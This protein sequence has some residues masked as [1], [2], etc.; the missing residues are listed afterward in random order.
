[1]HQNYLLFVPSLITKSEPIQ[2]SIGADGVSEKEYPQYEG[3]Q[4]NEA[5]TKF[6]I[7]YLSKA[8]ESLDKI[9]MLCTEEVR[10]DIKPQIG[11]RTTLDY[12]I[13]SIT[14]FLQQRNG[15]TEGTKGLFQ[16]I[17][18]VPQNNENE[19]QIIE[20]LTNVIH[21]EEETK[22]KKRIYIDFTGG[23]RSAALTLVFAGRILDKSGVEVAKILYSNLKM[24][25]A[26]LVG[27]IEECTKT[28]QIFSAFEK[29]IKITHNIVDH[30]SSNA[31]MRENNNLIVAYKMSQTHIAEES[32]KKIDS[33]AP[34]Q[35][36]QELSYTEKQNIQAIQRKSRAYQKGTQDPLFAI[37][38]E[39]ENGNPDKALS[40]FREKSIDVLIDAGIIE[41]KDYYLKNKAAAM[42]EITAVYCYYKSDTQKCTFLDAVRDYMKA[43]SSN[44]KMSPQAV[45]KAKFGKAYFTITNYLGN[46]PQYGFQ[47]S[48][49]SQQKCHKAIAPYVEQYYE[50]TQDFK[51][52][53]DRYVQLDRLYMG[54]GF[55]FAC[56]YG[57]R[58]YYEGY[59]RLYQRNFQ[60]GI[61]NLQSYY[62]GEPIEPNSRMKRVL[63]AYPEKTPSYEELIQ[64]LE[65]KNNEKMLHI[66]F[67]Y[68]MNVKNIR[69]GNLK[70]PRWS[71]F[72][73]EFVEAYDLIRRVRNKVAHHSTNWEE[74][75]GQKAIDML[76][77]MITEIERLREEI[78]S[79]GGREA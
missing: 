41:V 46:V 26:Q 79:E 63:A 8:G 77:R 14:A 42:D 73:L 78:K 32:H 37:K 58:S 75:D 5:V 1:M 74:A 30:D 68:Q 11:S 12:Y 60:K 49:F 72:M 59:D 28:Y 29:S 76:K 18:Y 35:E 39:L 57:G 20:A 34:E 16:V 65:N 64:I 66:L 61:D 27:R 53:L 51:E 2:Y 55:P 3:I 36:S 24:D 50:Q 25:G 10:K 38:Q 52:V 23:I 47:H 62:N 48:A 22:D 40:T 44:I 6:L 15:V 43:L 71:G 19:N 9:I 4:T 33:I 56:T 70:G 7:D 17:D 13:D 45:K 31:L 69:E 21:P 54:Y 67:P